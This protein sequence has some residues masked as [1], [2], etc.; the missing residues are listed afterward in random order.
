M[1]GGFTVTHNLEHSCQRATNC[2]VCFCYRL[3]LLY[4]TL[5]FL[6]REAFRR[7]CLSGEGAGRN[8]RQVIN[9]LWLT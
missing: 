2:N 3:M 1:S 6:S 8:W 7:A 4:S 9:L 5:V